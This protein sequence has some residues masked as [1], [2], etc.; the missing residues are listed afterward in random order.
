M[1]IDRAAA[2]L[3]PFPIW[4]VS[5][6][7]TANGWALMFA[8]FTVIGSL[9]FI[10]VAQGY[11]L[12][13]HLKIPDAI[14][15]TISGDLAFWNEIIIIVLSSPFGILSDRYGRR[16]V[17]ALGMAAVAAG[18]AVYALAETLAMLTFGRIVYSVGAA[19]T[20]AMIATIATD[21]PQEVSRGK[22]IGV[23]SL[24]NALG[25]V[26][27]T[28]VLGPLP[29]TLREGGMD[30]V[31][32]GQTMLWIA[33]G[34]CFFSAIVFRLALKGGAPV[35][36]HDRTPVGDLIRIGF[37]AACNPRI[38]LAYASA[39]TARGDLV[40]VGLFVTLWAVQAGTA[41]GLEASEAL[42][43]GTMVFAISQSVA[44]LWA[45]VMGYFM[46][47]LNRVTSLAVAM[48]MAACGYLATAVLD[49]PLDPL[50]LPVFMVLAIGQVSALMTSQGL[51]GQEA[52]IKE[53][54]AVVGMFSLWGAIGVLFATAAGGRLFDAWAPY[55][56]FVVMGIANLGLLVAA[57]IVRLKAPGL[58]VGEKTK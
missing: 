21:Y 41:A 38:G 16:P 35:E 4:L 31:A 37:T 27:L 43:R 9:A 32:A 5:G 13:E 48:V 28:V 45:P 51:I 53:R 49:S 22:M 56:P 47:R 18:F 19:A 34:Y 39:F 55:A 2:R 52:P 11:I 50:G 7:S 1:D 46:D 42:K 23:G 6:V 40:V 17:I 29:N 25:I 12:K 10:N 54:G 36:R 30:P 58:M 26:A 33:A 57:M 24:M 15:G 14:Q 3:K 8:N 20:S 44:M